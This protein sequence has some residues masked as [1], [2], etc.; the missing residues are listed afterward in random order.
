[1]GYRGKF[2][3]AAE[4]AKEHFS[5]WSEVYCETCKRGTT[6]PQL[7]YSMKVYGKPLCRSCQSLESYRQK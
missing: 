7:L 6:K 1:M 5:G 2:T 4:N 3:T